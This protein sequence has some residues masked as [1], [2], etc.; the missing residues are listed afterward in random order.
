M[1]PDLIGGRY[2]VER[3]I[4]HGGM[5]T[6]WLCHD[7][8]LRRD[9]AVKQV[10]KL[11]G[12]SVTDSA[13]ALRE[14]RSSAALDHRN[15]V[16]V[17]DVV[18]EPQAIWLVM[19]HVASHSLSELVAQHG[20][21]DPGVVAGIGA[22]VADGLAAAH[23]A[24]VMHRDVK[25]GN[26]LVREDGVAKISDFGIA[27]SSGDPALTQSGLLT[28]TPGY[29]SPQ[30]ARGE[31]PTPLDDV[32]ALGATLYAAVEGRPP[33][34][35]QPNPIAV[36]HDIVRT[37]PST[38]RKAGPLEPVLIRMLERDPAARWSMADAAQVLHRVAREH[39]PHSET[40]V[41][42]RPQT[43]VAGPDVAASTA[44]T[45]RDDVSGGGG[46]PVGGGPAGGGPAGAGPVGAGPSP[47]PASAR[48][49]G[50][51]STARTTSGRPRRGRGLLVLAA[52]LALLVLAGGGYLLLH[53]DGS[54]SASPAGSS[55]RSPSSGSSASA[56]PSN[57]S[58][59]GGAS[60]SGASGSSTPGTTPSSSSSAS[61]G[62]SA[63]SGGAATASLGSVSKAS[64]LRAYFAAAPGGNDAAWER[65]GPGE[66]QQGRGSYDGFWSGIRSVTV[67]DVAPVAGTDA[68][69]A[70]VRYR[71][72]Q[73]TS[74]TEH[75]R[76]FLVPS[77]DGGW[78]IDHE[79]SVG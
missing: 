53:D 76:F 72:T 16:T 25:P 69:D 9:V 59:S 37:Q 57:D 61:P 8:V 31:A 7:E 43:P 70:T 66:Q 12:E 34:R 13:R 46:G 22:Q 44:V 64:F 21:L 30:L 41:T 15:V 75:K 24:G 20:A 4:G 11:P 50:T 2:R 18:E 27:R 10:G 26:V 38:P 73:G 52:L 67:S 35:L 79:E 28:G 3:A 32:W 29:F 71:T 74:S 78:L 77:P 36:M 68:V 49:A 63:S 14:A 56:G 58:P 40:L 62:T 33:Y 19:E 48:E 65:L 47:R 54:P 39:A 5:G 6:V 23:A 17:Y 55:G 42:T 51:R 60:A 45:D 1:Q